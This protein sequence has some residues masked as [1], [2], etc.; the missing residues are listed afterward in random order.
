MLIFFI[1]VRGHCRVPGATNAKTNS[2]NRFKEAINT[3]CDVIIATVATVLGGRTSRLK[4]C[5]S[6]TVVFFLIVTVRPEDLLHCH[7]VTP[8]I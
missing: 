5:L 7:L 3:L 1:D 4:H 6:A 2:M 8:S